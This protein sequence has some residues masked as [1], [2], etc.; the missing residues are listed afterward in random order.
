LINASSKSPKIYIMAF[1]IIFLAI[2][3]ILLPEVAFNASLSG[4]NMWFQVVFPALLPFLII[5][6]LLIGTGAVNFIGVLLEP[7]MRPIFNVP[8]AG[9][10][11]MAMG[12]TSGYPMGAKITARL[13][14]EGLCTQIEAERLMAFTNTA[15]PLFI[16]GAISVGML[17]IPNLGTILILAHYIST[18]LIG[19]TMRFYKKGSTKKTNIFKSAIICEKG[20]ILHKALNELY[21]ARKADKRPFAQI[22]TDSVKDSINSGLVIGG[23]IV[24]FSV[25][26]KVLDEIGIIKILTM[27][28]YFIINSFGDFSQLIYPVINGIFEISTGTQAVAQSLVPLQG[29]LVAISMI[30]AWGGLSVMAQVAS[31]IFG[32]DIRLKP[33]ILSRIYH[34]ILAS[35]ITLL[36]WQFGPWSTLQSSTTISFS[37]IT[38][39]GFFETFKFSCS[40]IT[41]GITTICIAALT[42]LVAFKNK[43]V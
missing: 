43:Q 42:C 31:M 1:I 5:C 22:L 16:I 30:I 2:S 10:F 35:L 17:G 32:T 41:K 18:I 38:S 7:L 14:R 33:Y 21:K 26:I 13:R 9:G 24:L 20:N 28:L 8:G 15:D 11:A 36:L 27:P 6:E 23:C 39:F 25:I 34:A 3:T 40:A 4:L 29:K 19:I 37:Q 12:L